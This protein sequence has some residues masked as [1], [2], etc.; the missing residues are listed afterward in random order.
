LNHWSKAGTPEAAERA[1][2]ILMHMKQLAKMKNP[3]LKPNTFSYTIVM[4]AW[5]QSGDS[6]A[7]ERMWRLYEQMKEENVKPNF[8]TYATL[9]SFFTKSP[10]RREVLQRADILLQDIEKSKHEDFQPDRRHYTPVIKGWLSIGDVDKAS[11]VLVRQIQ[12]FIGNKNAGAE[13]NAIIINM[14][15]QGWVKAGDLDRATSLINKMQALKDSNVLPEGP[16]VGTYK[17]L[18]G[19]WGRS[20]HPDKLA[21]IQQLKERIAVLAEANVPD[22]T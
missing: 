19:A 5:S 7:C 17:S 3:A 22:V 8:V 13:P 12:S 11:R 9:I 21:N 4:N 14:V 10:E 1:E 18:L 20:R 15:M 6:N 2:Q 16:N